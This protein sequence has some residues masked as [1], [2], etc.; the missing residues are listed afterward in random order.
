MIFLRTILAIIFLPLSISGF[1]QT[2]G[3][4]AFHF[5]DSV[6]A[7]PAFLFETLQPEIPVDMQPIL[8]RMNNAIVANKEWFIEYR[9]KYA[10][11]GQPL[12]Y[13]ERFGITR[14]EYRKVQHLESQPPQLVVVDSQ[15]VAVTNDNGL[16]QFR[17]EGNTHLLDYLVIDIRQQRLM[18]G[19]D[20]ILYKGAV[21]T[22]PSNPYGQ[23][24]G[25]T[26]RLEQTDVTATLEANKP[27]ARVV[28]VD[29]GRTAQPGKIY[30]RI[31]YQD[32]KAGVTTANL[33]LIGYIR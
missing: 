26:W 21:A 10:A 8:I 31:E 27:T 33:E 32:M 29:L 14:E 16:I 23:W 18:Y 9:T 25:Y 19:G 12:P 6:F 7:H 1:A 22:K 2:P 15:K 11:T 24:Q 5:A 3:D 20:T 28:E 13:N 30:L 4:S 17:S